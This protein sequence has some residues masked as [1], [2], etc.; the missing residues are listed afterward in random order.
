M[1][2]N[3]IIVYKVT[4]YQLVLIIKKIELWTIIL[5]LLFVKLLST[6]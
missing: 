6:S 5:L 1:D 3:I 2:N 4:F